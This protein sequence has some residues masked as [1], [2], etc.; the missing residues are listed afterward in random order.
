[1][2]E[3]V[4]LISCYVLLYQQSRDGCCHVWDGSGWGSMGLLSSPLCSIFIF[5]RR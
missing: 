1:M 2:D 5:W 4:F 3:F